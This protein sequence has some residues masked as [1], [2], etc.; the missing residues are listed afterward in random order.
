MILTRKRVW[1]HG[2]RAVLCRYGIAESCTRH[3]SHYV[4]TESINAPEFPFSGGEFTDFPQ[5]SYP[6][7]EPVPQ[8]R[9]SGS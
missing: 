5:A 2:V 4:S 1:C 7:A 8:F 3:G 9:R 6:G